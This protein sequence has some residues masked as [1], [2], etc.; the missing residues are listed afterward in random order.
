MEAFFAEIGEKAF[1]AT[2]VLKWLH[3]YGV[4]NFDAMSNLSKS[5]REKLKDVAEIRAPE[6]VIDQASSDGTHKWLLRLDSGHQRFSP[7]TDQ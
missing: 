6:M 4:D 2:Q 5:L 7:A 3:Q 1:R